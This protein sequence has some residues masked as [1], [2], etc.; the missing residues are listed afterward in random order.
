M[1]EYE[2]DRCLHCKSVKT[3]LPSYPSL[4]FA[5]SKRDQSCPNAGAYRR[6]SCR[7]DGR[8]HMVIRGRGGESQSFSKEGDGSHLDEVGP[9]SM[10]FLMS[11]GLDSSAVR[12]GAD[13][14]IRA[15]IEFA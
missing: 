14:V 11:L 3:V 8:L 6:C 1:R 10:I 12:N 5:W 7:R 9:G 4:F 15:A 13:S 2:A